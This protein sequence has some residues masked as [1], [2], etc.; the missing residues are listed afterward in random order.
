MSACFSRLRFVTTDLKRDMG[1]GTR[2]IGN[3]RARLLPSRKRQRMANSEQR[4]ASSEW[5]V[6]IW[7]V[8]LLPDRLKNLRH[9]GKYALQIFA[10]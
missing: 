2:N 1:Q 6:V 4:V 9:G 7:R 5:R 10:K 8:G 3:E